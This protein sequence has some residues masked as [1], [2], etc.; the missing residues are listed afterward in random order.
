MINQGNHFLQV[1]TPGCNILSIVCGKKHTTNN[2][3]TDGLPF[4]FSNAG[5]HKQFGS[6]YCWF[7]FKDG[8]GPVNDYDGLGQAALFL[9]TGIYIQDLRRHALYSMDNKPS[10]VLELGPTRKT[11]RHLSLFLFFPPTCQKNCNKTVGVVD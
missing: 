2:M 6:T 9:Y 5:V 11:S 8:K 3:I 1:L 10:N 7:P 4:A